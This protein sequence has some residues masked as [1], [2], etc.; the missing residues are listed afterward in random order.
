MVHGNDTLLGLNDGVV[1]IV[2]YALNDGA[3]T[4]YQF[5]RGVGGD[6]FQ[7]T[8]IANIDVVTSGSNTLL[9]VR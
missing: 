1:D 3:D 5:V 6:K 2:K 8:G 4:V 7:F 9:R